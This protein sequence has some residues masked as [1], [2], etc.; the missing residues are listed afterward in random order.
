MPK[1]I[2]ICPKCR[3]EFQHS[4]ISDVGMGSLLE[5]AKPPFAPAGNECVC[6]NCGHSALYLRTDLLYRA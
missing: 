5:P 4:Q 6:P 2:L 3:T 1:W